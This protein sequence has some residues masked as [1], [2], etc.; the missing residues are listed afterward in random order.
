MIS[1]SHAGGDRLRI[2]VRGHE[3]FADQ[4][5]E[6]GGGDTAPTPTEIFVSG[7]AACVAFYGE[8]FLRRHGIATD[9]LEITC[10]YRWAEKPHR[11]GEINLT[12]KAP[13]IPS[14]K[15]D[16]FLRVLEHCTVDN[17]LRHAPQ[18]HIEVD[19]P[20]TIAA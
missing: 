15:R 2:A 20:K 6:D 16:A 12:V 13:A 14:T 18:V 3:L 1:V 8:R 17:T 5:V 11:V 19:S 4:P 9:E 10:D 7:L